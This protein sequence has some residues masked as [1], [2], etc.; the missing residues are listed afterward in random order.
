MFIADMLSRAY[1]QEE[2]FKNKRDYQMFQLTEEAQVYK[3]IEKIDL[4]KHV[5]L[6]AKGIADP[7]KATIQDDTLSK[8]AKVIRHGWLNL[9][10][11]VSLAI[12]AFGHSEMNW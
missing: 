11:N 1:L 12:Q 3:E 8:L 4:A 7:R 10:Q 6:S 9:K 2:P 5:R